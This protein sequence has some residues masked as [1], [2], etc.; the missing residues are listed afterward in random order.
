MTGHAVLMAQDSVFKDSKVGQKRLLKSIKK[1]DDAP[2]GKPSKKE[3]RAATERAVVPGSKDKIR[4]IPKEIHQGVIDFVNTP[5]C[6]VE[7]LDKFF[8]NPPRPAGEVCQCDND[9]R[10]RGEL[11]FRKEMQAE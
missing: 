8:D 6:R 7:I 2:A 1:E 4:R 3:A 10:M 9:R 5:G 11:T